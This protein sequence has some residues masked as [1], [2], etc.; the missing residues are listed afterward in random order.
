MWEITRKHFMPQ[1]GVC[2]SNFSTCIAREA[3]DPKM[4]LFKTNQVWLNRKRSWQSKMPLSVEN[5]PPQ[6]AQH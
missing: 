3:R 5:G 2:K 1:K 4:S 6:A